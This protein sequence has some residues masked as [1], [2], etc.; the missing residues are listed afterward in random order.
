MPPQLSDPRGDAIARVW[1]TPL[2]DTF[3]RTELTP[4]ALRVTKIRLRFRN[5]RLDATHESDV[6]VLLGGRFM[7]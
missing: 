4:I 5:D 2:I 3:P 7:R 6:H 1:I